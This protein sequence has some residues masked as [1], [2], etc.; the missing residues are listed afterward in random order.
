[1]LAIAKAITPETKERAQRIGKDFTYERREKVTCPHCSAIVLESGKCSDC[2]RHVVLPPRQRVVYSEWPLKR[3]HA[4]EILTDIEFQAGELFYAHW[5]NSGQSPLGGGGM[6][7]VD[8][9]ADPNVG[10]PTSMRQAWHRE[11]YRKGV[12]AMGMIF[13]VFVEAIVCRE[14]EPEEIGRRIK[15]RKDRA[16]ARAVAIEY[17]RDGLGLLAK[18][19]ELERRS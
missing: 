4:K 19:Y 13:S 7:R 11:Q 5:Y 16:Q 12:Q 1:M 3:L 15:G 10:M 2:G 17:L 9:S 8:R 14:E 6:E 18:E